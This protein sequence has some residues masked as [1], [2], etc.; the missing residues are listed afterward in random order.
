MIKYKKN[1]DNINRM[2]SKNQ[3]RIYQK[4]SKQNKNYKS[5]NNN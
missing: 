3:K 2:Q 5:Y 4:N 1:M